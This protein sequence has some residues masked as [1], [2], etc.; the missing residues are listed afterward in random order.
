MYQTDLPEWPDIP[1]E[2]AGCFVSA[3]VL[4]KL[5]DGDVKAGRRVLRALIEIE[6]THAP[7]N[8]PTERPA[9]VRA[10][11]VADE[12][13]LVDLVRLD[14]LENAS[15]IAPIDEKR[16]WQFIQRA[17]RD[18]IATIGVIGAPGH[19]E[20]MVYLIPAQWVWSQ[21]W[22]IEERLTV[23][24]PDHRKS[25]HAG[26][27]LLFARWSADFTASQSGLRVRLVGTVAATRRGLAKQAI[28]GRYLNRIGGIYAYP[29]PTRE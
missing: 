15:H 20:G 2:E 7:I 18:R 24:H 22:F 19:V 13:S 10:A 21:E 5:G 28:F 16:I 26:D 11:G 14:V 27:L 4:A 1:P 23:V 29:D 8:G 9:N 17:T 6:S 25:R 12:V 3:A